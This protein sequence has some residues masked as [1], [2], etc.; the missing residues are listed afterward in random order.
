[1]VP[2]HFAPDRRGA[3][4]HLRGALAYVALYYFLWAAA[5]SMILAGVDAGWALRVIPNQI[6][7][8]F[9]VPFAYASF[10]RLGPFAAARW[11]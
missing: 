8:G 9:W 7:Y 5:D 6:Y 1:W 4:R 10:F 11:R 2:A 3:R